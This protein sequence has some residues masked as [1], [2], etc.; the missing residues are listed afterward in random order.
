[1]IRDLSFTPHMSDIPLVNT[2]I[3]KTMLVI[4]KAQSRST[5]SAVLL[6]T[7]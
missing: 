5:D 3:S 2:V 1:M 7:V 6:I 4:Q